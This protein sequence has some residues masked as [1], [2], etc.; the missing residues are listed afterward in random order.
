MIYTSIVLTIFLFFSF[1]NKD[2]LYLFGL[3]SLVTP[4]FFIFLF[5]IYKKWGV[6]LDKKNAYTIIPLFLLSLCYLLWSASS[7]NPIISIQRGFLII[8]YV[9]FFLF[10]FNIGLID[11]Q[12]KFIFPV[13][14][15]ALL[16]SLVILVNI[17]SVLQQWNPNVVG[18]YLS[19]LFLLIFLSL[20]G[21][22]WK[23]VF[24]V[25]GVCVILLTDSR[26]SFLAYLSATLFYMFSHIIYRNRVIY[27]SVFF[28]L[29]GFS[30]M[31]IYV[32]ISEQLYIFLEYSQKISSKNIE[33][34]RNVIWS[35]VYDYISDRPMLGHGGGIMLSNLYNI[36]LSA[37]NLYLQIALQ[38][39]IIGLSL[40][41]IF[42]L[43]LWRR[44]WQL[45]KIYNRLEIK[46]SGAIF[47]WLLMIQNFEIT[48]FQNNIIL[49]LPIFAIM[50]YY[51]GVSSIKRDF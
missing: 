37:H 24:F 48:L 25:L 11:K 32:T 35:I 49:S 18:I 50:S 47:V 1:F 43:L 27:Y 31:V 19:M 26:T 9:M 30:G 40:L 10:Y 45:Y 7:E 13:S 17:N 33:S 15:F 44:G 23:F 16:L 20:N 5:N 21:V 41:I 39:G 34:G 12:E 28:I 36:E 6:V 46:K 2:G 51:M 42:Y 22:V 29:I 38:V 14:V 8:I 4:M 3:L